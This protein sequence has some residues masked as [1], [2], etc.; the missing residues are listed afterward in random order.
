[1]QQAIDL[2]GPWSAIRR[3][4]MLRMT[5]PFIAGLLFAV[6][7]KPSVQSA[8]VAVALMTPAVSQV[9][10]FPA[11][12]LSRW[13][14]G[15]VLAVWFFSFGQFWYVLR[16]PATAPTHFSHAQG[17]EG[18]WAVRISA[19]NSV[20]EKLV[21][22]DGA[23]IA[24]SSGTDLVPAKGSVMLALMRS[25]AT[26]LPAVGDRIWIDAPLEPI[27]RIPDPGGF[28]VRQW[29]ASRGIGFELFAPADRWHR[30]DHRWQWTDIFRSTRTRVGEWLTDSGLPLRERALIKAL[31]LGQRDELDGEQ[32]EDFARSGTI[33]VLAVSG[34]HVGLIFAVLSFL[35]GWWGKGN[36]ARW[37]RGILLLLALWSYAGLT[38]GSPSV[39][40]ATIMFSLFTLAGMARQRTDHLNSLFAAALVLL[41]LD[42][43]MLRHAG[44]QLSFLA[45]LGIILFHAPIERLW[46]P[47]NKWVQRIWSL[48]VLSFSA[49]LL[50]APL[51]LYVFKAFPIWFLP[52]N[53]V[54]V[55]AIGIAVPGAVALILLYRI[56]LLGDAL[57]WAM[58]MLLKA[59]GAVTSYF[60]SLPFAYPAI[61]ISFSDMVLL[62]VL[63]L[64]IAGWWHWR[65]RSMRWVAGFATVAILLGWGARARSVLDQETL[66]VY[67]QRDGMVASLVQ[68]RSLTV[69]ASA[70][71]LLHDPWSTRKLE[72]HQ[73]AIGATSIVRGSIG[74][75]SLDSAMAFRG[76]VLM[77]GRWRSPLLDIRFI[78]GANK[79]EG[80][81]SEH[82]VV[83]FHDLPW[84]DE[85][86]VEELVAGAKQ[87]VIAAGVKWRVRNSIRAIC[88]DHGI[89][90]HVIREQGAFIMGRP[91]DRPFD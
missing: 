2:G 49:Q 62:Y 10:F 46:I 38:G 32:K 80:G 51:S 3:S 78:N 17:T 89:P 82:A 58:T 44:F 83:V 64:A 69:L 27:D 6:G 5:V 74:S 86:R 53:I 65:W 13:Q 70:D 63:V 30:V 60:A 26:P 45:V 15:L 88:A 28:D 16:L 66:V 12:P 9:L 31:V 72:K 90:C 18:P 71:S 87:V 52:A 41:V 48:S 24:R 1:M 37:L 76:S 91:S 59:V 22:A 73:R 7:L 21:R 85:A 36:G 34:M 77:G 55:T 68:G 42:P 11:L 19:V 20:S 75:L 56:P 4:P 50:T 25:E 35:F 67:D 43:S 33:H 14:R 81:N 61:R 23:M 57:I 79:E 54:V 29:A 84:I 47:V 39:L 8:L 40:R